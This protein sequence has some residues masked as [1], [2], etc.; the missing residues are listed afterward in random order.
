MVRRA[1][2]TFVLVLAVS[3]AWAGAPADPFKT[4]LSVAADALKA[5]RLDDA[6]REFQACSAA[7][8]TDDQRWRSWLG[9]A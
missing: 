1:W 7:A 3:E 6:L 2:L 8:S 9:L 4:R 5:G